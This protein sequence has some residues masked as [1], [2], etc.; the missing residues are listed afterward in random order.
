MKEDFG[1]IN[2]ANLR[3]AHVHQES[4]RAIG[5]SVLIGF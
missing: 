2:A 5:E 3:R 1:P 4:G